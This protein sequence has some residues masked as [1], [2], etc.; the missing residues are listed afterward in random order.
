MIQPLSG[1]K[2]AVARSRQTKL[3]T[4]LPKAKT[5]FETA[6]NMAMS[7]FAANGRPGVAK[8]YLMATDGLASNKA[9]AEKSFLE[10][11]K[12]GTIVETDQYNSADAQIDF[13]TSTVVLCYYMLKRCCTVLPRPAG[14][15]VLMLAVGFWASVVPAPAKWLSYPQI[16]VEDGFAHLNAQLSEVRSP[17]IRIKSKDCPSNA[18]LRRWSPSCARAQSRRLPQS[19]QLRS[20]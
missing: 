4:T 3:S 10:A 6:T 11:K 19:R 20:P 15:K 1:D 12:Q 14:I 2:S 13:R 9:A 8:I 17:A 7:E 16:S 5:F 18:Y